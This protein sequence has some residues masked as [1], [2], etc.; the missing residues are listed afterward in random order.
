MSNWPMRGHFRYLRFKTFST[1]PRTPQCEVF[2]ALL[3]SSEHPGGLQLLTFSKCW[4]SP[5][6]LAKVGLRHCQFDSRPEKV[7][8]R[9]NLLSYKQ[10]AT[11]R[12][13][14]LNKG[15]NFAL[16]HTS[17]RGLLVKLWGSKVV[18]VPTGAISRLPLGSPGKEKPFGCEPRGE[19]QSIL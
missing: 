11:Y 14:A 19:V 8:N 12:W 18:G 1:T 5:P 4:A 16:D 15:Y 6:H 13:K 2:W 7:R 3:S 10:C 9:P 17:I